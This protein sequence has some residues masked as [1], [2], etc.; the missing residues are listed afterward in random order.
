MFYSYQRSRRAVFTRSTRESLFSLKIL[1][2]NRL[3]LVG[4]QTEAIPDIL[5][6]SHAV[7]IFKDKGYSQ[8]DQVF[9]EAPQDHSFQE[10]LEAPQ[11]QFS[12]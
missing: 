7:S 3:D 6:M 10:V 12:Q 2:K 8:Q 11:G 1:E 5:V 9:H 4:W